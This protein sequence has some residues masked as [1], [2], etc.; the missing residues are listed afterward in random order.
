MAENNPNKALKLIFNMPYDQEVG[1]YIVENRDLA[2]RGVPKDPLTFGG[3][4]AFSHIKNLM[5]NLI[6]YLGPEDFKTFYFTGTDYLARAK[7]FYAWCENFVPFETRSDV[8]FELVEQLGLSIE[9]VE[10][11]LDGK[12]DPLL[13]TIMKPEE[14]EESETVEEE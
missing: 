10:A 14:T 3:R 11:D 4:L 13:Q 8:F 1:S 6:G 12:L 9:M 7:A 5:G 2:S